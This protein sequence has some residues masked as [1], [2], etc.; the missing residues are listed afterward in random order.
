MPPRPKMPFLPLFMN[1][2][3]IVMMISETA[4][5]SKTLSILSRIV[6]QS[7]KLADDRRFLC[8]VNCSSILQI[9]FQR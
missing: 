8:F 3:V 9:D 7:V 1:I 4:K 2:P 6:M 5:I